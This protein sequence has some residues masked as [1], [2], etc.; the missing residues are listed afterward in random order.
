M[1]KLTLINPTHLASLL[2]IGFM[3]FGK[4]HFSQQHI[5]T[6]YSDYSRPND[7]CSPH[8]ISTFC[9]R[10]NTIF[11]RFYIFVKYLPRFAKILWFREIFTK[12][13]YIHIILLIKYPWHF[14]M[15]HGDSPIFYTY[16]FIGVLKI[17]SE[18]NE[19]HLH[20]RI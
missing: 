12:K 6:S 18:L 15:R 7:L 16:K 8:F 20:Y 14:P 10:F 19:W 1:S 11:T 4:K 5:T 17:S 9:E 2:W 13:L 3:S